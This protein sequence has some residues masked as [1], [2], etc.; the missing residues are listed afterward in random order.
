MLEGTIDLAF[1][2]ALALAKGYKISKEQIP[3]ASFLAHLS[4]DLDEMGCGD[5][6]LS[7]KH[8]DSAFL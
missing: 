1:P 2:M 6:E 4:S 5:G 8:R 3:F 7:L